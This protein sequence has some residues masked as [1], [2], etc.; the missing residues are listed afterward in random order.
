MAPKKAKKQESKSYEHS[1]ATS[2]MRP[3]VGT[4]ARLPTAAGGTAVARNS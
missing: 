1:E 3:E 4:Q 2:P